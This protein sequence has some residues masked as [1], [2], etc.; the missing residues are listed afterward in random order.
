MYLIHGA[1]GAG[2]RV[3]VVFPVRGEEEGVLV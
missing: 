3:R 1:V 2:L